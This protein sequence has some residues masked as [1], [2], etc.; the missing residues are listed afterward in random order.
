MAAIRLELV[1]DADVYPELH[2]A[3]SS[4]GSAEAR[5]ERV[6]QLASTGLVWEAVRIH[7]SLPARMPVSSHAADHEHP[8]AA[9][10]SSSRGRAKNGLR[11]AERRAAAPASRSELPGSSV[12]ADPVAA[13]SRSHR[14]ASAAHDRYRDDALPDVPVLSDVVHLA[15]AVPPSAV[16]AAPKRGSDRAA[17]AQPAAQAAD[18]RDGQSAL[19]T[20]ASERADQADEPAGAAVVLAPVV[21]LQHT[22]ASRSR[23]LRMKEKGLFRNG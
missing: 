3:L 12:D 19:P 20:L 6:R 7:G 2:A 14:S 11:P 16:P 18:V 1:V 10:G 21:P 4:I 8:L 22:L 13:P 15:S 23:L 17:S 5:G 9:R